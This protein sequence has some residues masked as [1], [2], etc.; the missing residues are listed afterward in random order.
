MSSLRMV[1]SNL[2]TLKSL[3]SKDTCSS[4]ISSSDESISL[5][6]MLL[7]ISRASLPMAKLSDVSFSHGHY[8]PED[9]ELVSGLL[10]VYRERT[11]DMSAPKRIGGGTYARH[12]DTAVAFGIEREYR[13]NRLHMVDEALNMD[14]FI[15]DVKIMADAIVELACVK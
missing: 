8:V 15:E 9:S 14:D 1:T 2:L 3:P 6:F 11:G 5:S 10:K 7:M 12:F 4:L 13:E